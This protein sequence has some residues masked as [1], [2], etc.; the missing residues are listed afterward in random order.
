MQIQKPTLPSLKSIRKMFRNY[1]MIYVVAAI[2]VFGLLFVPRFSTIYNLKNLCLQI[3]DLLIIALG[4]TF[5]VLNG[6]MDFSS[7]SVLALSS[8]TGAYIMALSPI[9]GTLLSVALALVAMVVIGGI[10]GA[11][12]GIS[13]V[14]F[15]MPS[16]VVTLSMQLIV[17]GVAIYFTSQITSLASIAGLP[18]SFNLLGGSDIFIVPILIAAAIFIFTNW[19]CEKSI[20]G[21]NALMVGA[22]PKASEISGIRVKKTIFFLFVISGAYAGL[23]SIILTARNQAGISSLGE[24]VFIDVMASIIIGGTSVFGGKGGAKNTL[25]GVVFITLIGNIM[26]L[27]GFDWYVITLIKGFIIIVAALLDIFTT[28]MSVVRNV[29][30]STAQLQTQA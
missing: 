4:V 12:N 9:K 1:Q 25:L 20:F 11:I 27:Y 23:Q 16:F 6:G 7:T 13:V 29:K 2:F 3:C 17:S 8:V 18:D 10:V 14:K 19:L 26:N 28:R 15:K 30:S 5:T 22:N 24:K 21:R